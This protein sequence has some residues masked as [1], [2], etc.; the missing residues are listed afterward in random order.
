MRLT[1][2]SVGC[3]SSATKI[4]AIRNGIFLVITIERIGSVVTDTVGIVTAPSSLNGRAISTAIATR[5]VQGY[6]QRNLRS[7]LASNTPARAGR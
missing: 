1:G 2:V 5:I 3:D 7:R 6:L 4:A